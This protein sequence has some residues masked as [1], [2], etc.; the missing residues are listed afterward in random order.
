LNK[1]FLI[2]LIYDDQLVLQGEKLYDSLAIEKYAEIEPNL[3]SFEVKDGK[4]FEPEIQYPFSKKQKTNCGCLFFQETKTCKHIIACLFELRK[5]FKEQ[6][7]LKELKNET[8]RI[9]KQITLNI[10]HIVQNIDHNELINF[11][12]QYAKTDRKFATQ[13][14]VQFARKIDLQD[15]SDKYKI[16]LNSLIKPNSGIQTTTSSDLRA[17]KNVADDFLAQ[18]NDCLALGQFREAYHIFES[19]FSK[20]EYVRHYFTHFQ[21]EFEKLSKIF[22]QLIQEFL[23]EKLIPEIKD[24]LLNFLHDLAN[25]SYYHFHDP[26]YNIPNILIDSNIKLYKNKFLTN[27]PSYLENRADAE[28]TII[29][30]LYFK[31]Q[32]KIKPADLQKFKD[33]KHNLIKITDHLITLNEIK[34]SIQMLT[35]I[36]QNF[37]FD[38][39]VSNRLVFLY[40]RTKQV[41]LLKK[42]ALET[43]FK[44]KDFKYLDTIKKEIGLEE[45]D[46]IHFPEIERLFLE[47]YSKDADFTGKFYRK[48]EKWEALIHYLYENADVAMLMNFDEDL[49]KHRRSDIIQ[50][51]LEKTDQYLKAFIG[52]ISHSHIAIIVK[53]LKQYRLDKI[54]SS[55]SEFLHKNYKHR[56]TL[57]ELF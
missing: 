23:K 31:L 35:Y 49:Y 41:D 4:L 47:K 17:F 21:S 2:E 39:E 26:Y 29:H 3:Y 13:L 44:T 24:E 27:Y 54:L 46:S 16:I 38:K 1:N 28:K 36:N 8:I 22:H 53:H 7:S 48:E 18:I 12:K 25:R 52:D 37:G 33:E 19:T 32:G 51:Y 6:E 45:W 34:S 15:N 55:L 42:I 30:A 43:F 10:N 56:P 9:P 40:I 11:I 57:L 14:K 5:L 20:L 50:I